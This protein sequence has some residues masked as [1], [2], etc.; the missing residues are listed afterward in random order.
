MGGGVRRAA[1]SLKIDPVV[2]AGGGSAA[3][4]SSF[5]DMLEANKESGIARPDPLASLLGQAPKRDKGGVGDVLA[6]ILAVA[7]DATDPEGRGIYTKNLASQWGA[8][9]DAYDKAMAS[10]QNRQMMANLPGMTDREL[11]AYIADPKAWGGHM[12]DAATSRYQAATLNPGDQRYLGEGNGVY[13]A[14]TRA[15]Q[16]AQSLNL[17]PGTPEYE[18]ALRDQELGAQG[19]TGFQNSMALEAARQQGRVGMESLRQTGRS[20]LEG[21]RQGNRLNLEGVRQGNR[22]NLRRT[23]PPPRLGGT[24]VAGPAVPTASDGKGGTVYLRNG[25]W[26]DIQGRPVQ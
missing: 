18:A 10:Y 1:E 3:F 7:A 11:A 14:P 23:P 8:R 21:V 2:N 15:E 19:P 20:N 25:R 6:T 17:Q 13:Q 12:A 24:A 26:V 22:V 9:R 16:Y 5:A 4:K